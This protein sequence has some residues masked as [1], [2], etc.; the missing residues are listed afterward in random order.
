[1]EKKNTNKKAPIKKRSV[2][3]TTTVKKV[4]EKKIEEKEIIETKEEKKKIEIKVDTIKNVIIVVLVIIVIFGISAVASSGSKS[5][6]KSSSSNNDTSSTNSNSSATDAV[7]AIQQES[8][9]ISDDEKK[10]LTDIDVDKFLS[11]KKK[12]E[13]SIIY[14]A[15]PTCSYC[16]IEE[17]IMKNIAYKYDIE[18]NYLNTDNFEDDDQS[19][20]VS[21]DDYFSEGFGTPLILVVK[22][23]SIVEKKEGLTSSKDLI[24][25]FKTNGFISE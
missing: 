18:I 22:D 24:E 4:P 10:E 11:L 20:L 3:K 1:M 16:Q 23:N 5:Y 25:M 14:I 6:D 9:S 12:S 7:T 19:K 13:A 21:S 15:R 2:K 17:P 8:S